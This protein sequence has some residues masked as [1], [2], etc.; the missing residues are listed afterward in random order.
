M[1]QIQQ[2]A[3]KALLGASIPRSGHHYLQRILSRYLGP[4]LHYCEW[5]GPPDCCRQIPCSRPRYRV[6]YQKNHDWDFTLPQD[7]GGLYL[8]QYR[9]PVPEA[10]SDRDLMR[11]SISGP[12]YNYRLTR[13]HYGWWLASKALYYRRFHQKWFERRHPNAV[14]L[15]YDALT[16]EPASTVAPIVLWVDG[17]VDEER[18]RTAIAEASKSRS[19]AREE[20]RPRVIEDSAHFDQDLLSAFEAY[21]LEHCPKFEFEPLLAGSYQNHWLHGLILIQDTETPLPPG[22]ND[23]L[24]AAARLAPEHPEI[25]FRLARR[26]IER[27]ENERAIALLEQIIGRSPFFG[28]AYRLLVDTCRTAGQPLPRIAT[29]SEALF[30]CTENPGA[31]TE[32]ARAMV[33]DERLANG[34][35]ALSFVTVIQPENFRANHLLARTLIRLGRWTEARRFAER[36]VELKPDHEANRKLLASIQDHLGLT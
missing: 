31:L 29:A 4:D 25:R 3:E 23:R 17:T 28:Q 18:L 34:V 16:Q 13:D 11:D 27:G 15:D 32:I 36:G 30:A 5:Y 14:Y 9:H 26:E 1:A 12:S 33:D 24:D 21:V 20:Y 22:E 6:T 8:V 19:A 10:L 7:V 35:A 2:H